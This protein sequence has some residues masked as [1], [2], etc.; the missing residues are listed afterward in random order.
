MISTRPS[1]LRVIPAHISSRN[2]PI[3]SRW[4]ELAMPSILSFSFAYMR[5][6]TALPPL[7]HMSH[8][9]HELDHYHVSIEFHSITLFNIPVSVGRMF[10]TQ[11]FPAM[12]SCEVP[13]IGPEHPRLFGRTYGDRCAVDKYS[14]RTAVVS[15]QSEFE[16]SQGTSFQ[17]A[18]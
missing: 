14:C 6:S 1:S 4:Y 18:V 11:V 16:H 3:V 15:V 2:F 13:P 17:S 5:G 12:K 9:Y 7:M 8:R 10:S